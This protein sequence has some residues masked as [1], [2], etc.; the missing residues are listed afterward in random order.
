MRGERCGIP[1]HFD[2]IRTP[3][4][5]IPMPFLGAVGIGIFLVYWLLGGE[6][7]KMKQTLKDTG[8]GLAVLATFVAGF[9][10]VVAIMWYV[11]WLLFGFA[12]LASAKC[13][14][15]LWRKGK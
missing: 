4:G 5:I 15:E 7:N 1:H 13:I 8:V 3:D 12:F 14:G 11:P 10:V 2:G 6:K 9:G